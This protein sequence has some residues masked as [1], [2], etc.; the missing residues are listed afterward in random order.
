MFTDTRHMT[1]KTMTAS[2]ETEKI[3]E[4]KQDQVRVAQKYNIC[5]HISLSY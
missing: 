5:Q 1:C 3:D 2:P 4:P